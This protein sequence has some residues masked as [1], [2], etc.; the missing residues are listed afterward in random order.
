[1]DINKMK[2]LEIY[3]DTTLKYKRLRDEEVEVLFFIK[4]KLQKYGEG[5]EVLKFMEKEKRKTLE[6]R[7]Y[8]NKESQYQKSKVLLEYLKENEN[9]KALK[10]LEEILLENK[11]CELLELEKNLKR[12]NSIFYRFRKM[13]F[14]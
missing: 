12:R 5:K 3:L 10:V 7:Y 6:E 13:L 8:K 11:A 1:M 2:N 4:Y 9:K 14:N